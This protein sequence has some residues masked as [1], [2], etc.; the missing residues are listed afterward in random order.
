[1][2][3]THSPVG[4]RICDKGCL[5]KVKPEVAKGLIWISM[6]W[7]ASRSDS[8]M[9]SKGLLER[10]RLNKFILW[11]SRYSISKI[12]IRLVHLLQIRRKVL[13][14]HYPD[15]SAHQLGKQIDNYEP[16]LCLFWS[17]CDRLR[18]IRKRYIQFKSRHESTHIPIS[19]LNVFVRIGWTVGG[20]LCLCVWRRH[21]SKSQYWIVRNFIAWRMRLIWKF[22]G[23][24][25]F[26]HGVCFLWIQD[27]GSGVSL[28][29]NNEIWLDR[30]VLFQLIHSRSLKLNQV[31][32]VFHSMRLR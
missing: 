28:D 29:N 26:E 10:R 17:K 19:Y 24:I 13:W 2:F 6:H 4:H 20:M 3:D 31:S 32:C 25:L 21:I 9:I 16:Y 7:S 14:F 11:Q 8:V 12:I 5:T 18:Q 23:T 27:Y 30:N 22:I 1:M 15:K